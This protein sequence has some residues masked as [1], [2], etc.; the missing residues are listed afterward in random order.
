MCAAAALRPWGERE[1]ARL[2][3]RLPVARRRGEERSG[4]AGEGGREA[5]SSGARSA[6]RRR[7]RHFPAGCSPNLIRCRKL[8]ARLR[9][10]RG[11][12][13]GAPCRARGATSRTSPESARGC[14]AGGAPLPRCRRRPARGQNFPPAAP[15]GAAGALRDEA[16]PAVH[17]VGQRGVLRGDLLPLSDAGPGPLRPPQEPP[18]GGH[19]PQGERGAFGPRRGGGERAPFT[20]RRERAEGTGERSGGTPTSSPRASTPEVGEKRGSARRRGGWAGGAGR[21]VPPLGGAAERGAGREGRCCL[22]PRRGLGAAEG[23]AGSL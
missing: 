11:A 8:P 23:G 1:G 10:R 3:R 9:P 4:A 13:G 2:R 17:G 22:R 18:S 12:P 7:R 21:A 16:E 14:P 5:G 15:C 6:P 20:P 19:L